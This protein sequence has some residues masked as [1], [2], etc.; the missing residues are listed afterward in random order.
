M[1]AR[2]AAVPAGSVQR[3]V[4]VA[5]R[6]LVWVVLYVAFESIAYPLMERLPESGPLFLLRTSATLV[7]ALLAGI[8]LL[9]WLDRRPA[10]DL[11]FALDRNAVRLFAQGFAIGVCAL[12][13]VVAIMVLAG[14]LRFRTEGGNLGSWS[15]TLGRDLLLF[16]VAG[17]AEEATFRGYAFQVVARVQPVLAVLLGSGAFAWAHAMNRTQ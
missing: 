1:D 4:W 14:W 8:I 11:G 17:A 10:T 2:A 12:L 15:A 7:A 5:V 16:G 3:L 9:R 6:I 13:M